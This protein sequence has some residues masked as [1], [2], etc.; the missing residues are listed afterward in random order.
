MNYILIMRIQEKKNLNPLTAVLAKTSLKR[1]PTLKHCNFLNCANIAL[2][3][4]CEHWVKS[5]SNWDF[6]LSQKKVSA[7]CK[8]LPFEFGQEKMTVFNV[9]EKR[10]RS[11]FIAFKIF[12]EIIVA[13]PKVN[14]KL[15]F[16]P[17]SYLE[18]TF[19]Y[20]FVSRAELQL[21][22]H[23]GLVSIFNITAT[24]HAGK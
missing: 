13:K 19:L 1:L 11:R 23:P 10:Q 4:S 15:K 24:L 22:V 9:I 18:V 21:F 2:T 3:V 16:S 14:I 8:I 12:T 20:L 6:Q 7:F 17:C 5:P